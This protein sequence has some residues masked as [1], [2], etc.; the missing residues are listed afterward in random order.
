LSCAMASSTDEAK[1]G[2]WFLLVPLMN[3]LISYF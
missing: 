2:S 3:L 1:S